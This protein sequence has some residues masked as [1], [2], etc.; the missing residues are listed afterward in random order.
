[1]KFVLAN[2]GIN[3]VALACIG[4]SGYLAVN[5]KDGW[6]WFLFAALLCAGSVSFGTEKDENE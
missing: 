4:V 2:L 6:G 5:G 1:M 3:L